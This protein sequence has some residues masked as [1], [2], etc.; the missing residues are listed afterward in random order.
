MT[1]EEIGIGEEWLTTEQ[2]AELTGYSQSYMRKL[3][4]GDKVTALKAGRDWLLNRAALLEFTRKMEALG[5]AKHDPWRP[6]LEAGGRGRD[7]QSEDN[8]EDQEEV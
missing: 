7:R 2:A 5:S 4:L 3:A 1:G 8:S 6:D